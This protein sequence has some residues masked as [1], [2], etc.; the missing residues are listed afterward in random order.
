M[1]NLLQ[2]HG[3]DID[4]VFCHNDQ[5]ALGAVQ[6]I[7]AAGLKP[8]EDILVIGIDGEMDAFK[9]VIAGEMSATVV[10]SPMYGPITFETVDKVLAG[11]EVPAETIM[12]GT[13]VDA[14]NA[15]ENMHLAY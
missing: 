8:N 11:E 4:A 10:S 14:G 7:K 2:A 1:E 15:E 3:N 5:M 13:V 12:E 6:A 9:S